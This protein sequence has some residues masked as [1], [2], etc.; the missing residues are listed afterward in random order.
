MALRCSRSQKQQGWKEGRFFRRGNFAPLVAFGYNGEVGTGSDTWFFHCKLWGKCPLKKKEKTWR[1]CSCVLYPRQTARSVGC[2]HWCW[3][4]GVNEQTNPRVSSL[5]SLAFPLSAG[6]TTDRRRRALS[7]WK[8]SWKIQHLKG[9]TENVI[10]T[11]P[12]PPSIFFF[13]HVLLMEAAPFISARVTHS[14]VSKLWLTQKWKWAP[15]P[16]MSLTWTCIFYY[17][18]FHA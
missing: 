14:W 15:S 9:G 16:L 8:T 5:V 6:P 11:L 7:G 1:F 10:Q 18:I 4:A 13:T 3:C 2:G 12:L 17:I